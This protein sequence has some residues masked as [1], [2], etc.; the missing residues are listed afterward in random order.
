M[1]K[2]PLLRNKTAR[3]IFGKTYL[4]LPYLHEQP[5]LTS[6][7]QHIKESLGHCIVSGLQ[8]PFVRG[9]AVY[10]KAS[11]LHEHRAILDDVNLDNFLARCPKPQ[12]HNL[13]NSTPEPLMSAT[14][15]FPAQR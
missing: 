14:T 15:A 7:L 2:K 4:L 9:K 11:D 1:S 5:L 13:T 10:H 12:P 6:F 3:G 8:P